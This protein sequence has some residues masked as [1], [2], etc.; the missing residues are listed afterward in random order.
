MD[1]YKADL[2]LRKSTGFNIS[3]RSIKSEN[4]E[5]KRKQK[6]VK[7]IEKKPEKISEKVTEKPLDSKPTH[8]QKQ[9]IKSSTKTNKG[10]SKPNNAISAM[11]AVCLP[12]ARA[13]TRL[14]A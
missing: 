11:F 2:E 10:K 3:L 4:C 8:E 14:L 12:S 6:E 7:I 13:A 9:P 1:L 5:I